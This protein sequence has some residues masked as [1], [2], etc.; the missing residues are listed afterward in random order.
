[1]KRG[2]KGREREHPW[3]STEATVLVIRQDCCE[4][5]MTLWQRETEIWAKQKMML[6]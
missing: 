6:S 2:E 1:V 5:Q 3:S 4:K